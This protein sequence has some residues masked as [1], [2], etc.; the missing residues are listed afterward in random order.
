VI[1]WRV[2][3][4]SDPA[5]CGG[6]LCAKGTRV[7]VTVILDSLAEGHREQIPSSHPTLAPEHIEAGPGL[8][9]RTRARGELAPPARREGQADENLPSEL[10][11]DLR[12]IRGRHASGEALSGADACLDRIRRD[13]RVLVTLDKG[14]ADIRAPQSS[15][16]DAVPTGA[17][18]GTTLAS[19]GVTCAFER[20][21]QAAWSSSPA[22]ACIR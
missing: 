8:R 14:H 18:R 16:R 10:L 22:A 9:G 3:L 4:I 2:Y 17:M 13:G 20:T 5:V 15:I 7:P 21:R 6:Q 19:S 1:Q 12:L 11:E